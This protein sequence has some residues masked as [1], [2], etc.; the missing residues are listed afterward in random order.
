MSSKFLSQSETL[1][2]HELLKLFQPAS[3]ESWCPVNNNYWVCPV[4][5]PTSLRCTY[6]YMYIIF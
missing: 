4:N 5:N 1:S 2:V 6:I 3:N